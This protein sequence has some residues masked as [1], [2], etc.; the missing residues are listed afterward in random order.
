MIYLTYIT[1]IVALGLA[2]MWP[3]EKAIRLAVTLMPVT[4]I[5]LYVGAGVAVSQFV[6]I[7]LICRL[8]PSRPTQLAGWLLLPLLAFVAW[9]L[10]IAFVTLEL[11]PSSSKVVEGGVFRNGWGRVLSQL[12]LFGVSFG[13]LYALV[14]S[15]VRID[16]KKIILTYV[17]ACLF[18]T[19]LGLIQVGIFAGTGF[20]IL[21]IGSLATEYAG[22]STRS[23][24]VLNT[25]I[26]QMLRMSSLGGEPKGLAMSLVIGIA[27]LLVFWTVLPRSEGWKRYTLAT[28]L[29]GIVL[30]GSTSGFFALLIF[31][32][33][34]LLGRLVRTPLQLGPMNMAACS[35]TLA[36]FGLYFAVAPQG[37]AI[38]LSADRENTLESLLMERTLDRFGLDDTDTIII[39][40]LA[41]SPVHVLFGR[42]MGLSHIGA[43]YYR[44]EY[45][46]RQG[47]Y[48]S[49]I[50]NPKSGLTNFG[51]MGGILGL[52]LIALFFSRNV[53]LT[54]PIDLSSKK[55]IKSVITLQMFALSLYAIQLNR[56]YSSDIAWLLIVICGIALRQ[57][58]AEAR[59]L[60]RGNM[61]TPLDAVPQPVRPPNRPR[62]FRPQ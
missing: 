34:M 26:G 55:L 62:T 39:R 36:L 8:V 57:I 7:V 2:V 40:S 33:I 5:E 20:N 31:V 53:A 60:G 50:I 3:V 30:T 51:G 59:R 16:A 1:L 23:E 47:Y 45:Y 61:T 11:S 4:A 19:V 12:V 49:N 21:P 48:E 22:A 43:E 25:P 28:L 35:L 37:G 42:G 54:R 17:Q 6:M 18:L 46:V 44:F 13:F 29:V 56:M 14:A 38:Q 58:Q 15:K 32:A 9:T 24:A 52:V 41:D 27:A 10:V